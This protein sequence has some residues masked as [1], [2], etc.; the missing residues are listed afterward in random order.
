MNCSYLRV[1]NTYPI[2]VGSRRGSRDRRSHR[3][4]KEGRDHRGT[5]RCDRRGRRESWSYGRGG[6]LSRAPK[7]S[8]TPWKPSCYCRKGSSGWGGLVLC[9]SSTS[10][11]VQFHNVG[12]TVHLGLGG[13]EGVYRVAG[14]DQGEA[15]LSVVKHRQKKNDH[16]CRHYHVRN[17]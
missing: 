13:L 9:M 8:N 17:A 4:L 12:F 3:C 16:Q 15:F 14:T 6:R 10:E 1:V 2:N 11:I 7:E 5:V